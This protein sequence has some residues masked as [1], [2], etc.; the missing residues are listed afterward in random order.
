MGVGQLRCHTVR[1]FVNAGFQ[2]MRG[3]A[4]SVE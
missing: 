4:T 1:F 3:Q 2:S